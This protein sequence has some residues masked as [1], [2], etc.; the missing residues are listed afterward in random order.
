MSIK[1]MGY[2]WDVTWPT[3]SQL[4]IA[5]KLADH[6][7]NEGGQV[8]PAKATIARQAQCSESTVQNALRAFRDCGLLHVVKEGGTGP[9]SPTVYTINVELLAGLS[10]IKAQLQGGSD[11]IE[12]PDDLYGNALDASPENKGSTVDPLNHLRGQSDPSKGSTEGSKGSKALTPNHH[13]RTTNKE[14][15]G[16]LNF[17]GSEVKPVQKPMAMFTITS[18]DAEWS[19]WMTYIRACG[20]DE[21]EERC[22]ASG[23]MT[24]FG[25]RWPKDTSP[26]PRVAA[27]ARN[28][29]GEAAE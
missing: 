19:A 6:A 28:V 11:K 24:V 20:P 13:L 8:Y 17:F 4:L 29:T 10:A 27:V 15:K 22:M 9:R 3:Q 2:V 7:N 26:L 23:K 14:P 16:D 21:L 12:I 18:A 25:S 5:L 1:L